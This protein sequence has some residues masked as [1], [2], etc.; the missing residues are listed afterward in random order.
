MDAVTVSITQQHRSLLFIL[1]IFLPFFPFISVR[2]MCGSCVFWH[3][4]GCSECIFSGRHSTSCLLSDGGEF[5]CIYPSPCWL[6]R[7]NLLLLISVES[8][9]QNDKKSF[10]LLLSS[11]LSKP[12]HF[13]A[14]EC[15]VFTWVPSRLSF[16]NW[17]NLSF[18]LHKKRS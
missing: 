3:I 13:R 16:T 4:W 12:W 17:I 10:P 18:N 8:S 5:K 14:P 9:C 7:I 2:H 11:S 6:P 15:E 1:F